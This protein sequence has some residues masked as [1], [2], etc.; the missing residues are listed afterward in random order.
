MTL[1]VAV[2]GRESIWLL[3]D[4]R[5]SS[6][7]RRPKDDARKLMILECT[8]GVAILGYAGLGVTSRG[9]EP[10]D[11]MTAVLRGRNLEL[12][13]S[14]GVVARAVRQQFPRHLAQVPRGVHAAHQIVAPAFRREAPRLYT[15][16]LDMESQ[17]QPQYLRH[18]VGQEG[19]AR[20]P[21][22]AVAGSGASYLRSD[23]TWQ[24]DLIRIVRAGDR[25]AVSA[26]AV[27]DHLAN[28]N[29]KVHRLASDAT[30]GP[31]SIVAWRYREGGLHKGGGG[32]QFYLDNQRDL[33]SSAIPTVSRGLDTQ[34]LIDVLVT[35]FLA[36]MNADNPAQDIDAIN[37]R[38]RNLPDEPD[39]SLR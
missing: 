13:E 15:I 8:D 33:G 29:F 7:G 5:L 3:A 22:I 24:R 28:L 6:P 20:P 31:N 17:Q 14:L 39:E 16:S 19:S 30:V 27:A 37:E 9:T 34:A 35:Q 36:D 26:L 23:K 1:V 10:A 38:L 25:Q 12:E 32:Y 11:W 18:L 21:R 2:T 4:R